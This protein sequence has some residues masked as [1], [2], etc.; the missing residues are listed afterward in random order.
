MKPYQVIL[1][2]ITIVALNNLL[3]L[4]LVGYFSKESS[5]P[6][7]PVN[8]ASKT[9]PEPEDTLV[10]NA[11]SIFEPPA[12]DTQVAP[13]PSP[14]TSAPEEEL[15]SAVKRF[16]TSKDFEKVLDEYQL[17]ASL[18][19]QQM[20]KRFSRMGASE[21]YDAAI[22]SDSR[23]EKQM[24]LAMLNQGKV[25]DLETS[26]LKVLYQEQSVDEWGKRQILVKLLEEKDPEA[27]NWA[28]QLLSDGQVFYGDEVY[29][30]VYEVDPDFVKERL[31]N[32]DLS[33][34]QSSASALSFVIQ[35]PELAKVFFEENFDKILE[36]NSNQIYQM[37]AYSVDFDLSRRQQASLIE[38]FDS[39]NRH[40]RSFAI[41]VSKNIDD[42]DVLRDAYSRLAKRKDQR[43]FLRRLSL[44]RMNP[45]KRS[46]VQELAADSD[47]PEIRKMVRR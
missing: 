21:L 46:L 29:A 38:F 47:D 39:T 16:V 24:A 2:V 35:E 17:S 32:L 45:D 36:S 34:S 5:L 6:A 4:S 1:I 25:N 22:N 11:E 14:E 18:R 3:V 31:S 42:V 23:T 20:Q 41:S 15:V 26:E 7:T 37:G 8:V 33:D 44:E 28:K 12:I 27:L 40:K 30:A 43:N 13:D 9:V 10:T 19:Y